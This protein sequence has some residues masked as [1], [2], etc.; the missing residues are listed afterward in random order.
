MKDVFDMLKMLLF[1]TSNLFNIKKITTEVVNI[2]IDKNQY[3]R[4][5]NNLLSKMLPDQIFY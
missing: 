3:M 2:H 1:N 4:H 5:S